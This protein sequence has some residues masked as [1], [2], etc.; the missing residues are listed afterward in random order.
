[1]FVGTFDEDGHWFGVLRIFNESIFVVAKGV[2]INQASF[3]KTFLWQV[4]EAI[5]SITSKGKWDSKKSEE[6]K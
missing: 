1:M 5:D 4:I 6:N 3:A 2:L